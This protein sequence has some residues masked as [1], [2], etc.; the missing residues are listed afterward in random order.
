[1]SAY[2][3]GVRGSNLT[4]LLQV[5]CREAGMITWVQFFGGLPPLELEYRPPVRSQ[6]DGDF[7]TGR[8]GF[9]FLSAGDDRFNGCK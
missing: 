4:N 2:N 9:M 3:F 8:R 1:M 7:P 6:P 5:T